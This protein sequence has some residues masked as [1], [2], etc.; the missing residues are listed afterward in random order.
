[1]KHSKERY[2]SPLSEVFDIHVEG[3]L[4]INSPYGEG[5]SAGQNMTDDPNYTYDI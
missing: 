1:M 5:G 3:N 4:M 2:C